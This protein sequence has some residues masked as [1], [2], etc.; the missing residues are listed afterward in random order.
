M[1]ERIYT[2]D[3]FMDLLE[4]HRVH[5]H[6]VVDEVIEHLDEIGFFLAPASI[7]HHGFYNGGLLDHSIEV[8]KSLA[9][10]TKSLNLVWGR[11]VSPYIIGW[12]HDLCKADSYKMINGVWTWNPDEIIPGHAEKSIIM[13]QGLMELTEEEIVCIRWHMGA[14]DTKE[15][16]TYYNR[17]I[18]R[19]SN[20]L[21]THTADM[22]ASK[23]IG[24]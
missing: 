21:W 2:K 20:V 9:L 22:V 7:N 17:A 14:F 18:S 24:I 10:L 6:F 13:L 19:Y 4:Q 23:I 12:F 5:N 1:S 15:N 8:A 11:P 16:W 3:M